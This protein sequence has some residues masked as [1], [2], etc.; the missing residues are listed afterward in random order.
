M[1]TNKKRAERLFL[2][3]KIR[4]NLFKFLHD[5]SNIFR[6]HFRNMLRNGLFQ[7]GIVKVPLVS[8]NIE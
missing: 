2:A 3:F 4:V 6:H 8:F 1:D 5:Q 7:N